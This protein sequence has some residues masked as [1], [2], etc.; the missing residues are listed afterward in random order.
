MGFLSDIVKGIGDF[1]GDIIGFLIGVD[2]D[3]FEDQ[4]QGSLV[5]NQSNVAPI[6]VIYGQRKVGGVR[7]FV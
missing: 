7:G 4:A 6:P 2:F 5:N 1:F 3:D